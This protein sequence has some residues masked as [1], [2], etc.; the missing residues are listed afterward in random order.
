[1]AKISITDK[2]RI[3]TLHELGLGAKAIKSSYPDR[4]WSLTSI[5]RICKV[6]DAA[7]SALDRKPG[8]GR[9]KTARTTN[10][11]AR[12][13]ELICSQDSQ[14]GTSKST[15]QVA[16]EIGI[17]QTSVR[18]IAKADIGLSSFKRTPVQ[19]ICEATRLKRLQRS[20]LLL[21]RLTQQRVKSVFFTDEKI[22]YL[23]PPVNTQNN[24]VWSSG[25]KRDVKQDRLLVQRAKFSTH[26]MV[27]AG[28]CCGG[29]GRLHFVDEKAKINTQYY[30]NNLL[31]KLFKDSSDLLPNKF[32]FQ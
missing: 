1:M 30:V 22:F 26:V 25:R 31:P 17:S 32:I 2:M 13:E 27:S 14:P 19:V 23:S 10:N 3:Q 18:R 15:R 29:K 11:I 20:K 12:V 16:R 7:G 4:K 6:I 21:R 8:S 9:P 24:R 28:I 5:K